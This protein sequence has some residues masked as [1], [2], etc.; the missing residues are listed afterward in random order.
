[1]D[2]RQDDY[3]Q[4]QQWYYQSDKTNP[5]I[6]LA[7]ILDTD[8]TG[9]NP[10]HAFDYEATSS[11]E[12]AFL[13]TQQSGTYTLAHENYNCQET[14]PLVNSERNYDES[15]NCVSSQPNL[16]TK[17]YVPQQPAVYDNVSY[18]TEHNAYINTDARQLNHNQYYTETSNTAYQQG[19]ADDYMAGQCTQ[20][21]STL[22]RD[23]TLF[24][25]RQNADIDYRPEIYHVTRANA[26]DHESS[27]RG[28]VTCQNV[29][30]VV[31][32]ENCTQYYREENWYYYT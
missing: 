4:T 3:N 10:N 32:H 26:A 7:S 24:G 20:G 25:T 30:M 19:S 21:S 29:N 11:F 14:E 15:S 22:L 17:H 6:G 8:H 5:N 13:P 12:Q 31:Q 28:Y 16:E 23:E 27:H 1:M 9:Y 18:S 2:K